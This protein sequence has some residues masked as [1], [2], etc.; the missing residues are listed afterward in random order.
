MNDQLKPATEYLGQEGEDP[1]APPWASGNYVGPYWSNGKLQE[2]VEWGDKPAL[3]ELDELARQH[4]AAYAHFKDERHREAADAIFADGA[5]KL[6]K[7]YGSKLAENPQFAAAMVRY[8]NHTKRQFAKLAKSGM[9]IPGL[10]PLAIFKYGY[11][12]FKEMN[13]RIKGTHLK[14]ERSDVEQFFKTDPSL[15]RKQDAN[16]AATKST[17]AGGAD[18]ILDKFAKWKISLPKVRSSPGTK[19]TKVV[20]VSPAPTSDPKPTHQE[21]IESQRQRFRDYKALHDAALAS[22]Y[23]PNK[24]YHRQKLY[25]DAAKPRKYR[26]N[27]GKRNAVRPL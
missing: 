17:V 25:L 27:K 8:G 22:K 16:R 23:D 1:T 10:A 20:K 9:F 5:E 3:N 15:K 26:K 12:N 7:K 2:S 4:D 6:K 24:K 14:A 13:A 21:L 18:G 19:S 11:D